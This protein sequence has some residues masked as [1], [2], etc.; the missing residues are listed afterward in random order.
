MTYVI[1]SVLKKKH[2][3]LE[4]PT[5]TGKTLSLLVSVLGIMEKYPDENY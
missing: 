2:S 5:G 4:S 3:I 1:K